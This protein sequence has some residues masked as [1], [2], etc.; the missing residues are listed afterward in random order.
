MKNQKKPTRAQKEAISAYYFNPKE[1][2]VVKET[3]FYL[4]IINK[5][6]GKKKTID[7]FRR[8]A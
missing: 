8:R 4:Y 7:K 2:A 1:W 3:E 5:E 6:T